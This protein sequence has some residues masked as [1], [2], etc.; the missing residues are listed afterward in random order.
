[1]KRAKIAEVVKVLVICSAPLL[2]EIG[3]GLAKSRREALKGSRIL[4]Y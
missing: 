4:I 3:E 2:P 1:L